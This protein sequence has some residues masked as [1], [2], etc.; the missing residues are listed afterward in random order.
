MLEHAL[1]HS[2]SHRVQIRFDVID[3]HDI[4]RLDVPA[5]S[6]PIWATKDDKPVL[7][8]RRNNSTRIVPDDE[9]EAFL[10]E[11]FPNTVAVG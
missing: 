2:G 3:G 8:E 6:R 4:C 7:Y 10:A 11:R 9:T 5:S 1:G